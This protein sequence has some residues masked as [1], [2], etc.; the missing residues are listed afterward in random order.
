[1]L[2]VP[3]RVREKLHRECL[4]YRASRTAVHTME[5]W[6]MPRIQRMSGVAAGINALVGVATLLVALL[7]IGP[8]V[9]ADRTR[10]IA[11]ALNNPTPTIIQD[12]LKFVA[13]AATLML[14]VVLFQR[15]R[16]ARPLII[17]IAFLFGVLAVLCL[18]AN[19]ILSLL[20]VSKAQAGDPSGAQLN[21]IIGLLAMAIGMTNGIWYLLVHWVALQSGRLPK[22]LSLLGIVIGALSLVPI[23]GLFGLILIIV[24]SLWLCRFLLHEQSAPA[25][26]A[27]THG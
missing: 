5:E 3:L 8:E 21:T 14:I 24:W 4:R 19:A 16:T 23:L 6:D 9:L 27:M 26:T 12:L 20:A 25:P 17:G 22:N 10:F 11:L 13:A 1:M 2:L 18:L 15:L 7:L